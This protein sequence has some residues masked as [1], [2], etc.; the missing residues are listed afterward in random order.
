MLITKPNWLTDTNLIVLSY[1]YSIEYIKAPRHYLY[2]IKHK[3]FNKT[4]INNKGVNNDWLIAKRIWLYCSD[5]YSIEYIK[6][7]RNYIWFLLQNF[8]NKNKDFNKT[9]IKTTKQF[10][11]I[12]FSWP[13][14]NLCAYIFLCCSPIIF[15]MTSMP[16]SHWQLDSFDQPITKPEGFWG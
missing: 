12:N 14:R 8:G 10:S 16:N 11:M 3:D 6:A 1:C 5:C 7:Q 13:I 9:P 4:P 2:M 15:K